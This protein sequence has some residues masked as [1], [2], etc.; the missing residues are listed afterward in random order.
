MAKTEYSLIV[1]GDDGK[2]YK[3]TQ[4]QWQVDKYEIKDS[5]PGFVRIQQLV[6]SGTYLANINSPGVAIGSIC[7]LV[8]APAIVGKT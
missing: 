7:I 5:A 4:D 1:V 2:Y 6:G 3:L 8:N